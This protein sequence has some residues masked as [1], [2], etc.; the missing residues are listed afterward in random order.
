M[1]MIGVPKR[2]EISVADFSKALDL[3]PIGVIP[4]D[5]KL[6]GTAANNGQMLGEVESTN[7]ITETVN[8]IALELMGRKEVKAPK[9]KLSLPF[10]SRARKK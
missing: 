5:P 1:N 2:P 7:K 8:Q 3:E 4:F 9:R 6:F 10:L